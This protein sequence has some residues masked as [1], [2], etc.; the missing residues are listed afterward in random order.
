MAITQIDCGQN[1]A[2][3]IIVTLWGKMAKA[4]KQFK[5]NVIVL[6]AGKKTY[7]R[8]ISL[9]LQILHVVDFS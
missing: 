5:Y 6:P 4:T 9:G 7:L 3:I 2:L 8:I 1:L